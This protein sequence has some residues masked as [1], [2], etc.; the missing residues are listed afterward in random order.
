MKGR[1]FVFILVAFLGM[2][3]SPLVNSAF[4]SGN[5]SHVFVSGHVTDD[6]GKNFKGANVEVTCGGVTQNAWSD[7]SGHYSV[8]F[9]SS[10]CRNNNNV[11]VFASQNGQTGIGQGQVN[12]SD[13]SNVDVSCESSPVSVPEFGFVPGII[14][15][16]TSAGSFLALK[17]KKN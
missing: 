17:R 2:L 10:S 4:A 5:N 11:T 12:N 6:N 15:A 14:A 1:F 16:V 3:F 8:S 9:S 7:G 13:S